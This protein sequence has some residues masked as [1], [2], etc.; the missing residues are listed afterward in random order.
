MKVLIVSDIHGNYDNMKKVLEN[1]SDFSYLIILGDICS[2]LELSKLLNYYN[3]KIIAVRGN[4]DYR[5]LDLLDFNMDKDYVLVPIDNKIFYCTHGHFYNSNSFPNIDYDVYL[6]GHTHTPLMQKKE[7][8][9]FL[10]PGSISLPRGGSVK[11]YIFYEDGE[12]TLKGVDDGKVIQKVK[13]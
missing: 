1:E 13:F 10:N 6:Q 5:G 9:I 8:R 11:S 12:F 3:Q 7:N 4:C 2:N